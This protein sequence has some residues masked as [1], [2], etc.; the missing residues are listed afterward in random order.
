[1][2]IVAAAPTDY[3]APGV[4]EFW[5][6]LFGTDGPFAITRPILLM[7]L[8]TGLVAWFLLATTKKKALVPGRG[9]MGTEAVYGLVRNGIAKDLIGSKEFMR[10]VPLLFALFTTILVNNLFGVIPPMSYPTMS[11]IGFPIALSLIVWVVFH[12]V[13]M[14][15][16]GFIGYWKSLV[17]AGLPKAM[18]PAIFFLELITDLFTR[19]VTLALRLFGNMFAG[20]ILIVLFIT[21]GWYMLTNGGILVI[22]GGVTWIFAFVMTLFEILVQFLQAYVFTLLAALYIGGAVADEH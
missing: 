7:V 2:S 15:K 21:G 6:P 18:I 5:Q 10:F 16:H 13:G 19:P 17:P 14:R 20:H 11:R 22:A 3:T 9:Q 4:E 1:M 12:V 8:A